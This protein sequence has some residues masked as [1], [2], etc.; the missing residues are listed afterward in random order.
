MSEGGLDDLI[1]ARVQRIDGP[2]PDLFV[3]TLHHAHLHGCLVLRTTRGA[4]AWGWIPE[5]PRGAAASS[6]VRLLRKHLENGRVI[7]AQVDGSGARLMVRRHESEAILRLDVDPANLVLVVDGATAGA[8]RPMA[9]RDVEPRGAR[10]LASD[11]AAL[12]REGP[13]IVAESSDAA[14]HDRVRTLE[15]TIARRRA[16]LARRLRAIEGDLARAE[17][18]DALRERGSLLLAHLHSIPKGAS[19]AEVTD[20]NTDPPCAI[21]IPIDPAR[22]PRGEAEALFRRARKLAR[23]AEIALERHALTEAEMARLDELAAR[24]REASI[25]ELDA[26]TREA[27][28]LGARPAARP[29]RAES[30]VRRPYRAFRA[31]GERLVLVGRSAADNDAL[32]LHVARPHDHWLH[33]RGVPGSHV[34]IPLER[35]EDCP[36]ELLVDAAHLAA[37]FSSARGEPVTEI[38]HTARRYVSKRRGAA[39]GAVTLTREKVMI[40]RVEPDRLTRLLGHE[41]HD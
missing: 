37:H 24:A 12:A 28:R 31:A 13:E 39:A 35:N 4:V 36:P 27:T 8:L 5:R 3:L 7:D 1:G 34:V 23:G 10:A 40:L 15:R 30:S 29:R 11:L 20:W 14:L 17:E 26:L 33:A 25:D 6:F 2:R 16:Q 22:G 41:D 19:E 18:A 38:Q 9:E 21:R 32:T